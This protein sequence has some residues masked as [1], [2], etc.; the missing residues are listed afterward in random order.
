VN[1][2]FDSLAVEVMRQGNA[3]AGLVFDKNHLLDWPAFHTD[4][5]AQDLAERR[6]K[7]YSAYEVSKSERGA[8]Q[9]ERDA[10][11]V[12]RDVLSSE[13][14]VFSSERDA[15]LFERDALLVERDALF[16]ERDALLESKSW[17]L[18]KP[19]RDVARFFRSE[20]K[21]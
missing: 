9:M 4:R 14:D 20:P 19:L 18:T 6:H 8:L 1:E 12:E 11:V 3:L 13:R 17:K 21:D 7:L 16:A 5:S 15:F 10:L 2:S